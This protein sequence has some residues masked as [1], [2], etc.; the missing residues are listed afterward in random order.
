MFNSRQKKKTKIDTKSDTKC[1]TNVSLEP[2]LD[3]FSSS[4]FVASIFSTL[5]LGVF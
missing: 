2:L 4:A 1:N 3:I 5:A